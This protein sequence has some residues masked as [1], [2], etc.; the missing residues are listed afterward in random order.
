MKTLSLLSW[1]ST[2]DRLDASATLLRMIEAAWQRANLLCQQ[3]RWPLAEKEVRRLLTKA[4][5]FAP[6]HALLAMTLSEQGQF[7]AAVAASKEAIQ[8][9]PED[10]FGFRA[11]SSVLFSTNDFDGAARAIEQAIALTPDDPAHRGMLAQIRL[12]Q[13][14]WQDCLDAAD[15]GLALDAQET[16][17]LNLRALALAKLGR[18]AEAEISVEASLTHD[19]ENPYTHQARGFALLQQGKAKQAIR[20]FQEALRRDPTLDG[21]RGGLVEAIKTKNPIY[22][23]VLA[24]FVWMERFP[25]ARRSQILIGVW[26]AAQVGSR[27]LRAAGHAGAATAVSFSWLG[28]ILVTACIVPIFNLMLLLHPIGRHALDAFARNHALLLGGALLVAA[29]LFAAATQTETAWIQGGKWF[30][31]IYLLPVAGLGGFFSGWGRRVQIGICVGLLVLWVYWAWQVN[32][33]ENEIKAMLASVASAQSTIESLTNE[34]LASES[35]TSESQWNSA[36]GIAQS[37]LSSRAAELGGLFRTML[38]TAAL[39]TWFTLLA[40]KGHPRLRGK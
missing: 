6:A 38:W 20:H 4:P 25:P 2:I 40:P 21:A 32:T 12:A 9:D 31:L 7:A 15:A 37:P 30:W 28:I 27:S 24:P 17:C 11:L 26:L 23:L 10:D 1:P 35:Q 5:D 22:R 29:S 3:Q 19:P 8:L 13:Q 33:L 14:R 39:S 16:D 18:A 34:S 36:F